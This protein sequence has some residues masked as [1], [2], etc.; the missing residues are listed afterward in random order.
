MV[1]QNCKAGAENNLLWSD[2]MEAIE[3]TERRKTI[4][5]QDMQRRI[6]TSYTSIQRTNCSL[7]MWQTRLYDQ[8]EDQAHRR[9]PAMHQMFQTLPQEKDLLWDDTKASGHTTEATMGVPKLYR[10]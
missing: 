9:L 7:A 10:R 4:S 6:A 1:L 2:E 8:T 5:V 3:D